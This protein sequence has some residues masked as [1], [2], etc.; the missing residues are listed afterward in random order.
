MR[1]GG[2]IDDLYHMI[3]AE[4]HTATELAFAGDNAHLGSAILLTNLDVPKR[5]AQ[6]SARRLGADFSPDDTQADGQIFAWIVTLLLHHFAQLRQEG[7]K[8][9][10]D[11]HLRQLHRLDVE[12]GHPD[13]TG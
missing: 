8:G 6:G 9:V 12:I 10:D 2:R 11:R 13:T 3:I 5:L 7:G 4:V 1:P